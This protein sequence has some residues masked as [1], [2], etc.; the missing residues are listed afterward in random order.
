MGNIYEYIVEMGS[1]AM[2]C[3]PEFIK[4]GEYTY[5]HTEREIS[6]AYFSLLFFK[7]RKVSK[8]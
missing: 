3:I 4:L 2:A 8:K 5:R 6:Q 1:G 7:R